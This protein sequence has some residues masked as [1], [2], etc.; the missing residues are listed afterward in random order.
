MELREYNFKPDYN[1]NDDD[2]A[3]DFYLPAMRSSCQYDRISGYFGSTIYIL[4]WSALQGFVENGGKIRIIC[5]PV[6]SE[7]DKDAMTEG[8]S[9]INDAIVKE[10]LA[11]EMMEIFASEHLVKPSRLLAC[12]VAEGIVDIKIGIPESGMEP[13]LERLFHDKVGI[14]TDKNGDTVGV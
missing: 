9:A 13:D 3:E 11:K 4:A 8:Y 5:S 10:T 7:A 1:K 12:L 6:L 2:I 14:F